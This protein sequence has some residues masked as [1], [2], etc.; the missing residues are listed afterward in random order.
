[1]PKKNPSNQAVQRRG[2]AFI[3]DHEDL[4][5]LDLPRPG[6]RHSYGI[7]PCLMG[8]LNY[9]DWAMFNSKP[10]SLPEGTECLQLCWDGSTTIV[11]LHMIIIFGITISTLPA[12]LIITGW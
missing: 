4:R 3:E 9:F 7:S 11:E 8:K 2:Q 5:W 10:V 12:Y 6:Q 1:M